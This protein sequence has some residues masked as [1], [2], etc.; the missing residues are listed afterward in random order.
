MS[1]PALLWERQDVPTPNDP[2]FWTVD[3]Y[4]LIPGCDGFYCAG[5]DGEIW[6]RRISHRHGRTDGRWYKQNP[7]TYVQS[8]GNLDGSRLRTQLY[9]GKKKRACYVHTLILEAFVGPRPR[10]MEGCHFPDRTPA[11]CRLDNLRWD[12]PKANGQDK[13]LHGTQV[14]GIGCHQAKLTEREVEIVRRLH[15]AGYTYH[16]I[17]REFG[18]IYNTIRSIVQGK[19][20]RHVPSSPDWDEDAPDYLARVAGIEGRPLRKRPPP[21]GE[22]NPKCKLRAVDVPTILRLCREGM[23]QNAVARR[24]GVSPNAIGSIVKGKSWSHLP[25]MEG[26]II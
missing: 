2:H 18:M 4:R 21:I 12:T 25:S 13:C 20:W 15:L 22:T 24:Y 1:V 19:T 14:Q 23:P 26:A 6:S 9:I 17:G 16:A 3:F 11:N 10:G 5:R 7:T 8:Y